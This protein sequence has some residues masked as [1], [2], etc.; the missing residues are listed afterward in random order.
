[1]LRFLSKMVAWFNRKMYQ[2]VREEYKKTIYGISRLGTDQYDDFALPYVRFLYYHAAHDIGHALQD[3]M[4]VGCTSFAAW[5][6]KT[7]DGQLLLGRNFDFYVGDAFSEEKII[8][9]INP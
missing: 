8:A 1:Y 4:L 5:G 3:L 6:E 9:F 7:A 2:N